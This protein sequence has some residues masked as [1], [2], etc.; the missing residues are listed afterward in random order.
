MTAILREGYV[1]IIFLFWVIFDILFLF[2]ILPLLMQ[3]LIL[4]ELWAKSVSY[5]P[6]L[7][8]ISLERSPL[9]SS[10]R[11][12]LKETCK[13]GRDHLSWF[14]SWP[15]WKSPGLDPEHYF[16]LLEKIFATNISFHPRESWCTTLNIW[17]LWWHLGEKVYINP[18]A[19]LFPT[20]MNSQIALRNYFLHAHQYCPKKIKVVQYCWIIGLANELRRPVPIQHNPEAGDLS[21]HDLWLHH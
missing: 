7:P 20:Q 3:Y 9:S 4:P 18:A 11:E 19:P 17:E 8:K 5:V 10:L 21:H 12:E 16:G 15:S 13:Y 2:V 1:W 14:L 6:K